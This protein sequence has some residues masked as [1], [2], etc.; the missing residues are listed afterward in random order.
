M[1]LSRYFLGGAAG[2]GRQ[3]VS[4]IH[5]ADLVR[6]YAAAVQDEKLSGSCNA[7]A[8]GAVTNAEFM[9]ELRQA[10]HRPWSPPVPAWAVKLGA[11]L[12]GSASALV[13][14]G[15]RCPPEKFLAAGFEFQ[16]PQLRAALENLCRR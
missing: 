1:R 12:T 11:R 15:Q 3:F 2:G 5:L 7:V 13:L 9:R 8:P 16:F 10:L 6:M 4:W 14:G